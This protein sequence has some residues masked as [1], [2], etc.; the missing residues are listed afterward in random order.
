[1]TQ[2]VANCKESTKM[3]NKV[4]KKILDRLQA[5]YFSRLNDSPKNIFTS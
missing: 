2:Y 4:L 1:M 5:Q 3:K